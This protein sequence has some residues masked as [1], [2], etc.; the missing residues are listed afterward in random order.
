MKPRPPHRDRGFTILELLAMMGILAVLFAIGMPMFS[1]AR[2]GAALQSAQE[3]VASVLL[4]ARW[5]AITSGSTRT[6]A[7]PSASKIS[8][9]NSA[10]TELFSADVGTYSV[11]VAGAGVPFTFDTRGFLSPATAVTFT[12]TNAKSATRTV[13]VS[14]LGKIQRS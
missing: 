14:P 6:V 11:T 7:L 1:T 5:A 10:G 13:T 3:T 4:R 8:I 9:R 2:H 12:L